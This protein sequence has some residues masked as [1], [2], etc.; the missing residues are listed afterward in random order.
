MDT[1][2]DEQDRVYSDKMAM[3][4]HFLNFLVTTKFVEFYMFDK[5]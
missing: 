1:G 5:S 3:N 4:D 2:Y